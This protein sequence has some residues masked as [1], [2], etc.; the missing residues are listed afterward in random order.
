[1][2]REKAASG[3]CQPITVKSVSPNRWGDLGEGVDGGRAR[4]VDVQDVD[5]ANRV[6]EPRVVVLADGKLPLVHGVNVAEVQVNHCTSERRELHPNLRASPIAVPMS[7]N[8]SGASPYGNVTSSMATI[9]RRWVDFRRQRRC[10]CPPYVWRTCRIDLAAV[11]RYSELL[12]GVIT[13]VLAAAPA[14]FGTQVMPAVGNALINVF[15]L[16]IKGEP[17]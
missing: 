10:S 15:K 5:N 9:V 16:K 13:A 4:E 1:M 8:L 3:A 11:A 6:L 2:P 14:L 7:A 12:S 17:V